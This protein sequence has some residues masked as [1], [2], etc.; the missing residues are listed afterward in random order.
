MVRV[1]ETSLREPVVDLLEHRPEDH[2][3]AHR[4]ARRLPH[5]RELHRQRLRRRQLHRAV[6]HH[7]RELRPRVVRTVHHLGLHRG[8]PVGIRNDNRLRNERVCHLFRRQRLH[9]LNHLNLLNHLF[10]NEEVAVTPELIDRAEPTAVDTILV[11][12]I[13]ARIAEFADL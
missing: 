5:T 10:R 7:H 3:L 1:V 2:H 4:R 12:A 6:A 9:L 13:L 11:R 8:L